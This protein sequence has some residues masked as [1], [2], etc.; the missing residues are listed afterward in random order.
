MTPKPALQPA[1]E[2]VDEAIFVTLPDKTTVVVEPGTDM[3]LIAWAWRE[4][5]AA[6][7]LVEA[8]MRGKRTLIRKLQDDQDAKR[9]TYANR[10]VIG[11]VF[12]RWRNATGHKNAKLGPKRF[13]AARAR[14]EEGYPEDALLMAV[15]G[16][17]ANAY[18]G[19]DDFDVC[20]RDERQLE[21]YANKCPRAIRDQLRTQPDEQMEM[22]A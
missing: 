14:L 5:K 8:D 16:L 18:E 15:E 9:K 6:R 21:R 1:P 20:M 13:D 2:C 3:W 11:R 10:D 12:D 22:P 4:E 17:A 7:E 19:N